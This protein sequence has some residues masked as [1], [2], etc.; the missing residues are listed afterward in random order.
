MR[1]YLHVDAACAAVLAIGSNDGVRVW[2]NGQL[3]HETNDG[4]PLTPDQDAVPVDLAAGWNTVML[5][6]IN[7]G[8][9]WG[10]TL[11][12]NDADG[13]PLGGMKTSVKPE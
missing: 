5:K 8:G 6:V 1:T 3:V 9:D 10:A 12:V 4:R 2:L 13:N 11:R 7:H